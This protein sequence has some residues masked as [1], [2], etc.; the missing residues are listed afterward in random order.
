MFRDEVFDHV[1]IWDMIA[2]FKTIQLLIISLDM[3]MNIRFSILLKSDQIINKE[4]DLVSITSILILRVR[5]W[6]S[7]ST[8]EIIKHKVFSILRWSSW[9]FM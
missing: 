6:P 4:L 9:C 5:N 1:I 7:F 8:D 3:C 2:Y